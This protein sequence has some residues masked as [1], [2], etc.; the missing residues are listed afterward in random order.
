M[1]VIFVLNV[2]H[3]SEGAVR[4]H[5]TRRCHSREK[6][7]ERCPKMGDTTNF[8]GGRTGPEQGRR[9]DESSAL[10]FHK[11]GDEQY[12]RS[13][14]DKR[15]YC[16]KKEK[17]TTTSML[18]QGCKTTRPPDDLETEE[19][20]GS[21][22]LSGGNASLFCGALGG[23]QRTRGRGWT[24]S[25]RLW[26]GKGREVRAQ[27]LL[28]MSGLFFRLRVWNERRDDEEEGKGDGRK[29]DEPGED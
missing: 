24:T 25:G 28:G 3:S 7:N 22:G 8:R 10:K 13:G 5:G 9:E 11:T 15:S 27:L 26:L 16:T 20:G 6:G 19:H 2:A 29:G 1:C 17:T 18:I 12:S 4:R 23:F 21:G 14:K